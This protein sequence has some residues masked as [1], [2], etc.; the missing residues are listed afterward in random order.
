MNAA[1]LCLRCGTQSAKEKK[2]AANEA[3]EDF[4]FHHASFRRDRELTYSGDDEAR[5]CAVT[6]GKTV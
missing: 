5:C 2:Q 3:G 1:R 4:V 6:K